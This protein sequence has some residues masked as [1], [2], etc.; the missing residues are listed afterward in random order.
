MSGRERKTALANLP[1]KMTTKMS[2]R[3]S[4]PARKPFLTVPEVARQLDVADR[5]VWRWI[6]REE[7]R[8]HRFGRNVRISDD[9]FRAF[10]A[11]H[12]DP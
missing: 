8:V 2:K 12:R 10:L 7:L 1:S 11:Q 3:P 5:T 4:N 9:D 6:K